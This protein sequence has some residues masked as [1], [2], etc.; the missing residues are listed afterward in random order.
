MSYYNSI[1]LRIVLVLV[2][3]KYHSVPGK[4]PCSTFQ[5]VT[6]T[7]DGSKATQRGTQSTV[8]ECGTNALHTHTHTH[9]HSHTH[10]HTHTYTHNTHCHWLHTV[11][12]YIHI[13]YTTIPTSSLWSLSINR[14]PLHFLHLSFSLMK[15]PEPPQSS[16]WDCICCT[17]P[18]P[19]WRYI[20][21]IPDPLHFLHVVTEP[22]LPPELENKCMCVW[23]IW[24]SYTSVMDASWQDTSSSY[25]IIIVV[26][27]L[28][29]Y[30]SAQRSPILL[31]TRKW[32]MHP[33]VTFTL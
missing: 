12:Q 31:R 6:V 11:S 14:F 18:G 26:S 5:G 27:I 8:W 30:Q 23:V 1:H 16:H 4:C 24:I 13:I 33:E 21:W 22:D 15:S 2:Q 3:C 17:I 19:I 10:T 28:L 29:D 20:V 9:T 7:A 32:I 25:N